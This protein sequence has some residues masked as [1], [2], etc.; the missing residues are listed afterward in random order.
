MRKTFLVLGICCVFA[1]PAWAGGGFTLFG[2]YSEVND[3]GQALGAG[4]RLTLGGE[5]WVG[6]LTWTWYPNAEDILTIAGIEDDLQIIPT[7]LGAR[8]LFQTQGSFKPYLGAG[9]TFFY[10][11]LN[12][13]SGENAV[14]AYGLAGFTLGAHRTRFF[15]EILYRYGESDVTYHT[16]PNPITGKMDVGGLG[17]NL[18]ITWAF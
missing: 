11:N 9:I 3:D 6:D 5:R 14:G 1:A 4:V 17:V 7:D 16:V 12:Q 2:S 8:Y 10:V 18:G 13:G 15:A